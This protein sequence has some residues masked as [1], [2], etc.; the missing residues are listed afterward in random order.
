VQPRRVGGSRR[1][2]RRGLEEVRVRW[3]AG[4]NAEKMGRMIRT[5]IHFG[6]RRSGLV[7]MQGG[8][9]SCIMH[10]RLRRGKAY[11]VLERGCSE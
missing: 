11:G 1:A 4:F 5:Q 7:Y 6:V 2:G 9:T 3:I 8:S 10:G